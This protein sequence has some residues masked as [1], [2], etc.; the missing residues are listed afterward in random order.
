[1]SHSGDRV[2]KDINIRVAFTE[3]W[4]KERSLANGPLAGDP[5]ALGNINFAKYLVIIR[6]ARLA[7][8]P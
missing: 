8:G 6:K 1:M 7:P 4:V 3:L 5:S 2:G